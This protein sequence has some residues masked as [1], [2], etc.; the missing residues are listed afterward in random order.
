MIWL[1][2]FDDEKLQIAEALD[3]YS[4]GVPAVHWLPW[5]PQLLN[6]LV[7]NEGKLVLNLLIQVCQIPFI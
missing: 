4:V 1:L 3:K 7:R 6:A 5:I 2:T